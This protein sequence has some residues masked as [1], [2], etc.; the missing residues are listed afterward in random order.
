VAQYAFK[1][2][3]KFAESPKGKECPQNSIIAQWFELEE[4]EAYHLSGYQK[5]W[6]YLSRPEFPD[7]ELRPNASYRAL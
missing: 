5:A 1:K 7:E 6:A 3:R 4:F 2:V